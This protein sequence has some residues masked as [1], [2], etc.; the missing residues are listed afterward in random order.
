MVTLTINRKPQSIF[1]KSPATPLQD[2]TDTAHKMKAGD[3]ISQ[4]NDKQKPA[5]KTPWRHMTKRQRKNR[6]RINHLVELWP[7][8]FNREKPKPLKVGIPDDLIQDIAI[9]K[10][11]FGAGTLRAAV[12][13]Y[14]QSPRYY[15]ALMADGARYGL[16]G[17][18]CGEVK[19]QEQ[20]EAETRLMM[21][22]ARK[23]R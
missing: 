14:V 3:R 19:P 4:Q 10:L 7:E 20:K 13:S 21:L 5:D 6:K 9:R 16:K 12:A 2:K 17:Q 11:A 22:N 8:L 18:P 15:R 23:H 1:S